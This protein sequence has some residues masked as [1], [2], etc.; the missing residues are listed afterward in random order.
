[1]L[2]LLGDGELQEEIR[3]KV[4]EKGL[5]DKVYFAGNVGNANEWYNAFD[6]FMLPSVW[7][8]LPV[9][10]VEAQA[11]DL[12]CIFSES[13]TKEIGL[14]KKAEFLSLQETPLVWAQCVLDK[15]KDSNRK[16]NTQLITENNYNISYEAIKLQ[17]RY[18]ELYE[19]QK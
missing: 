4:N 1:M 14:S 18:L 8:G 7:E 12:P 5:N 17:E 19:E 10:G 3:K 2:V 6:V 15:L 11:N 16:D 9:V 13:V